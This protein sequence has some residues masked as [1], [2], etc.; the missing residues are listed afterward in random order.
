MKVLGLLTWVEIRLNVD[1]DSRE[2]PILA[3]PWLYLAVSEY[4]GSIQGFKISLQRGKFTN[5]SGLHLYEPV[6][7]QRSTFASLL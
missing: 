3:R 2:G 5:L 4:N 6:S 7:R 1:I